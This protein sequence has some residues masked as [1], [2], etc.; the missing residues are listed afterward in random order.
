MGNAG[1]VL[2]RG[3]ITIANETAD[4]V[5]IKGEVWTDDKSEKRTNW[6]SSAIEP[7]SDETRSIAFMAKR[8]HKLIFS[9]EGS[10][11]KLQVWI[12]DEKRVDSTKISWIIVEEG[13][14]LKAKSAKNGKVISSVKL[15]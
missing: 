12:T 2:A 5:H 15:K 3:N 7:D 1:T 8:A 14:Y 6:F 11:S 4:D 9:I 10:P 13:G